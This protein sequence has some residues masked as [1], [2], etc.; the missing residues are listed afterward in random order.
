MKEGTK[1][2]LSEEG[3]KYGEAKVFERNGHSDYHINW[4]VEAVH[5]LQGV[6]A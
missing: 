6:L 3:M 1:W 5:F 2:V 4:G